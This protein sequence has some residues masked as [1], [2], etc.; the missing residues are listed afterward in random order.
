MS[1][2]ITIDKKSMLN[3]DEALKGLKNVNWFEGIVRI[4]VQI[5]S[6]AQL[7][8]T[9]KE[10][11]ITGRLKNSIYIKTP[12]QS[13]AD[14]IAR[15]QGIENK[16]RY[17]WVTVGNIKGGSADADLTTVK[18]KNSEGAVGTNVVYSGK[19]ER[20]DSYLYWAVKNINK[21]IVT[22]FK[23]VAKKNKRKYTK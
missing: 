12:N 18:L 4:L 16:K 23:E 3:V 21:D 1:A 5:K 6:L 8:L 19:I 13:E 7:R 17:T 2:Q 11:I 20:L 22:Y 14:K 9:E 10:H 15:Q